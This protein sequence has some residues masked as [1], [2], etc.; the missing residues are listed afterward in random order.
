VWRGGN[1]ALTSFP[2]LC[3]RQVGVEW[4]NAPASWGFYTSILVGARL[5]VGLAPGLYHNKAWTVVNV[6]HAIITFFVFHWVK[7]NPFPTYWAYTPPSA[8]HRTFWEQ[9]DRRW[10]NTPS[11]KFCTAVVV[12]LYFFAVHDLPPSETFYHFINFAS[13]IVVFIA[14]FPSMDDVRILG[15]NR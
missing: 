3:S 7:G 12:A 9:I 10:Q 2:S 11:R 1:A 13:F 15:I 4:L 6:L 5:F 14:K 8:D